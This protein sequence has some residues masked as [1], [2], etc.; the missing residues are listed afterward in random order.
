MVAI[1]VRDSVGN[2]RQGGYIAAHAASASAPR[3][4]VTC[5]NTCLPMLLL[6]RYLSRG[7]KTVPLASLRSTTT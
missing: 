1:M 4:G 6:L 7:R 3:G 5:C 2:D